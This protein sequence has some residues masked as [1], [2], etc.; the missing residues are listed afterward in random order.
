M[1][2]LICLLTIACVAVGCGESAAG[3]DPAGNVSGDIGSSEIDV[4]DLSLGDGADAVSALEAE[5]L[6]ATLA[7]ADSDPGF[8]SARDAVG[9]EVRDQEPAAGETVVEGDEVTITVSCAQI[10]WEN[11]EGAA[12][13]AFDEAYGA[14]F[15]D[16]CEA[17]FDESPT[18]SMFE[19]DSEYTAL[20]CQSENPGDGSEGSDVP[21]DVPDGP[22]A[23]GT[24]LGELDGCT[25]MFDHGTVYSLNYGDSS[26]T[27]SDCPL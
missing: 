13:E 2:V 10:D 14:G 7:D 12:W 24:E 20:D 6:T 25:S 8:D 19:D 22:E 11:Q 27:E 21:G 4:P 26:W 5:G 3:P 17:L 18:G 16:G 15:D 23:A 9:C 1:R